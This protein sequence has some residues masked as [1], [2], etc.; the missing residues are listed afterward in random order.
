MTIWIWILLI[1]SVAFG[2]TYTAL[3]LKAN[4]HLNEKPLTPTARSDGSSGGRSA[5]TS[6]TRKGKG[7]APKG[8]CLQ[9]VLLALYATWYFVL[10]KK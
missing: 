3:G 6:T 1:A 4:A 5:R 8:R 9:L 10:L 7:C 2:V